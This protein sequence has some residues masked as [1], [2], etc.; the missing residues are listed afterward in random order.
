MTTL[1]LHY[2]LSTTSVCESAGLLTPS[3]YIEEVK[4]S[5]PKSQAVILVSPTFYLHRKRF[6]GDYCTVPP[7]LFRWSSLTTDHIKRLMCI[8][9]GDNQLYVASFMSLLRNYQRKDHV[10]DFTQFIEEVKQ[11]CNV[12]GQSGPLDQR[13]ELLESIVAESLSNRDM[14]DESMGLQKAISSNMKLIIIDLT[15]PLLSKE[16]AN[17][18]FQ[19]VTE[20]F[21]SAPVKGGKVLAL[22]EAHKFM[23]GVKSDGLSQSIVNIARLM[24]HDGIRLMVSTQS[25]MALVPELLEL[26]S[27]AVLH[28]FYSR[29]WWDYLRQKL[30]LEING[31]SR[32]LDLAPGEALVFSS[33]HNFTTQCPI[34]NLRV[35]NRL[36]ADF[37]SSRVNR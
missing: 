36:T 25:P 1:V 26:V 3:P 29:N 13:I 7:L 19:V 11:V 33:R 32:V 20:Q 37:G 16:D 31:F 21:R 10:P 27:V 8:K 15:D 23:D 9:P 17:S 24:R 2:D 34:I 14:F 22:D 5:M 30:P 28:H 18:L 35:R 6:Y 4:V 12:R